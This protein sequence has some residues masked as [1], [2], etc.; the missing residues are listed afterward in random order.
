MTGEKPHCGVYTERERAR[1]RG[2][3]TWYSSKQLALSKFSRPRTPLQSKS[4]MMMMML[5]I[6][7]EHA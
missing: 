5:M 3:I 4:V 7:L 2:A 1:E 6:A